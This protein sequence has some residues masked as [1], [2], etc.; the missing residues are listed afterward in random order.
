[1]VSELPHPQVL[2]ATFRRCRT[3]CEETLDVYGGADGDTGERGFAAT[4]LMVIAAIDAAIDSAP[5]RRERAVRAA[6]QVARSA[7]EQ[8]RH[9]G[10]DEPILR[11]AAACEELAHRYASPSLDR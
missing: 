3:T 4:L 5:E 1:M 10:L 2:E 7:A 6:A 9:Y 11:C 8:I